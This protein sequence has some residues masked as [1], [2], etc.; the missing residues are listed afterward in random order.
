M[1]RF[2]YLLS[3]ILFV[4]FQ[5]VERI[6]ALSSRRNANANNNN[7]NNSVKSWI[8]RKEESSVS[9]FNTLQWTDAALLQTR[10]G[11]RRP[12]KNI[13][14]NNKSNNDD[15]NNSNSNN[16][17]KDD[18]N[19]ATESSA[20]KSTEEESE[21]DVTVTR[22]E[23]TAM[24]EESLSLEEATASETLDKA[25][26]TT[27]SAAAATASNETPF[28]K[29]SPRSALQTAPSYSAHLTL[30]ETLEQA[31]EF[32]KL[33]KLSH[34]QG[35]FSDAAVQFRN[36]ANLLEAGINHNNNNNNNMEHE[37]DDDNDNDGA[38]ARKDTP[39]SFVDNDISDDDVN[40]LQN[41]WATCRLHESLCHLKAEDYE[42]CIEACSSL[43][44]S[45]N[46]TPAAMIRARA[47]HRR[48]KA[49]VGIDDMDGALVDARSAAFLGDRKAVAYY[50]KLLRDTGGSSSSSSSGNDIFSPSAFGTGGFPDSSS[51][52]ESLLNK[53]GPSESGAGAFSGDGNP[54][55]FF[56]SSLLNSLAGSPMSP[57]GPGSSMG[58]GAGGGG[59]GSLAKSVLKSLSKKLEDE[60]THDGICEYLQSANAMQIQSMATMA[61]LQLTTGQASKLVS[62]AHGIT[63]KTI[64]TVVKTIKRAIWSVQLIRKISSLISKYKHVIFFV[65]LLQW[66]KSAI[67]RPIP[68]PKVKVP[69]GGAAAAA[70]AAAAA[71]SHQSAPRPNKV[72]KQATAA[73]N[74]PKPVATRPGVIKNNLAALAAD[75]R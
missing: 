34:D 12:N 16:N 41:E 62:I 13:N 47:H 8:H 28:T 66:T 71:N 75:G 60:S 42:Q 50:G 15:D 58:S 31:A 40:L 63:P 57:G 55:D 21:G 11:S 52:L 26:S 35:S 61:G 74:K 46:H 72:S 67:L 20:A 36:A 65:L 2:Y 3:L 38:P 39:L 45:I 25:I 14:N 54:S 64:R 1:P 68:I 10:G 7:I 18:N 49:K 51:L 53:S 6:Q 70:A 17:N 56:T 37:D 24:E 27:N 23:E 30:V 59:G 9:R 32:R 44:N 4:S 5:R 69:R 29:L 33:G 43:L 73:D 19:C 22:L 48:A